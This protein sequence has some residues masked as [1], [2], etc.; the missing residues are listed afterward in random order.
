MNFT[1][2]FAK[3]H[4]ASY[5]TEDN[6]RLSMPF[7]L[8][9]AFLTPIMLP[10]LF[11]KS[12]QKRQFREHKTVF[13]QVSKESENPFMDEPTSISIYDPDTQEHFSV[14][15][16]YDNASYEDMCEILDDI[17]QGMKV[18]NLV[19]YDHDMKSSC[20]KCV[21]GDYI[22]NKDDVTYRFMD[23]KQM[24]YLVR[25]MVGDID[26]ERVKEYYKVPDL[27]CEPLEYCAICAQ[28]VQDHD[29]PTENEHEKLD[30]IY[31]QLVM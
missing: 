31:E 11:F 20:F 14:N 16:I 17:T 9:A 28:I 30:V 5:L 13:Y 15:D 12:T 23:L 1:N 25:P 7:L 18:V 8:F 27:E 26:Y 2:A 6:A 29:A 19:S 4:I 24:F 3:E 10:N 22:D 21:M